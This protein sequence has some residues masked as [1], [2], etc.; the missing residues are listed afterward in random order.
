MGDND[1]CELMPL[2]PE[3]KKMVVA[4]DLNKLFYCRSNSF[5]LALT[6]LVKEWLGMTL[7]E[8]MFQTFV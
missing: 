3:S 8:P 1:E 5:G 2:T 6:I 4:L 7:N